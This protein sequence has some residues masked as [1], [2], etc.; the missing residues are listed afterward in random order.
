LA[1]LKVKNKSDN[2]FQLQEGI[3][4][5]KGGAKEHSGGAIR[6]NFP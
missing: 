3:T 1:V 6:E 2:N 4:E 5:N